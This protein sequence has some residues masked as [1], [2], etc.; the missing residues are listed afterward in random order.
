MKLIEILKENRLMETPDEV[1][2]FE[3]ALNELIQNP[4]E[5]DLKEYH[6]ILDDGCQHPEVMFGLVHFLESFPL[7]KQIQVFINVIPQLMINAP[8]WTKIL[9]NRILNQS[10]ACEVYQNL[11]HSINNQN[12]HFLYYLLEESAKNHL[13]NFP[14]SAKIVF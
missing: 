9:H 10:S 7:E 8:E 11:L 2:T 6:L 1:D 4:D 12:P 14:N 5:N 13:Q 3:T